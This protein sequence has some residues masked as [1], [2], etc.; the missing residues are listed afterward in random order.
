MPPNIEPTIEMVE[1]KISFRRKI[2]RKI[3]I[4]IRKLEP[5]IKWRLIGENYC[6]LEARKMKNSYQNKNLLECFNTISWEEWDRFK[7]ILF[8]LYIHA[9]LKHQRFYPDYTLRTK[10]FCEVHPVDKTLIERKDPCLCIY[11]LDDKSVWEFIKWKSKRQN[12]LFA[13]LEKYFL[14]WENEKSVKIK[15]EFK[16]MITQKLLM[17]PALLE[18]IECLSKWWGYKLTL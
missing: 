14:K 13:H 17:T 15:D 7:T 3:Q 8:Y 5:I 2:S 10:L 11:G 4:M 18:G 6:D 16:K 9:L 12:I 1:S